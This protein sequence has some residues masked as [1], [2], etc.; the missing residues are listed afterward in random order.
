VFLEIL[1][2]HAYERAG[3][4]DSGTTKIS[5]AVKRICNG[6]SRTTE[7]SPFQETTQQADKIIAAS[8]LFSSL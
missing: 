5:Q 4:T 2:D 7:F 1:S 3:M 6:Y 8:C